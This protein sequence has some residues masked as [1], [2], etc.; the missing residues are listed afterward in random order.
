LRVGLRRRLHAAR[1]DAC[2]GPHGEDPPLRLHFEDWYLL[3]TEAEQI[4]G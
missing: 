1:G 2:F 3:A 4:A